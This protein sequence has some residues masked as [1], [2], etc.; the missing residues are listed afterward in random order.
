MQQTFDTHYW[1]S[2]RFGG[3]MRYHTRA[4]GRGVLTVLLVMLISQLLSLLLPMFTGNPYPFMGIYADIAVTLIA[5]L[6]A[7]IIT[8]NKSTRFLLRFGTARFSVWL[9]NLLGLWCAMV[10]L[11]IGTLLLNMLTGGL[12]ALLAQL[13]PQ[14]F[15]VKVLF[16]DMQVSALYSQTLADAL[17]NLP[18]YILYTLE[19]TALFYL[20]GCCLRR[21]RILT[22]AII[23]GV[24]MLLLMLTLI[25]AVRQAIDVLENANE[26]RQILLGVQWIK[27]LQDAMNF[28]Q[29]QWPVIQLLA[30][31]GSL[32]LSYLCMRNT[33]QP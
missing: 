33:P 4:L 3:V 13:A 30:A 9:G 23:I 10:G 31:I 29:Y 16:Q 15:T 8:A 22:I 5:A 2:A 6:V 12:A 1:Q 18:T 19:W 11:L 14:R 7:G 21:N 24:P 28:I 32:P 20:L 17:R 26:Q 25:P 27:Y